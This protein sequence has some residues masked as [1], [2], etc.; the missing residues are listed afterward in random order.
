MN[1]N[2]KSS[3]SFLSGL[4]FG[5][6]A[7]VLLCCALVLGFQVQRAKDA[8][9]EIDPSSQISVLPKPS[10]EVKE[11]ISSYEMDEKIEG[12][13]TLINE[14]YYKDDVDMDQ[15]MDGIY[16]GL[17]DAV[18]DPYTRYYS[19]EEFQGLL[20]DTTGRYSGIGA[21]VRYD[22]T[23]NYPVISKPI[24][25]SP[26]EEVGLM[27]EDILIEVD[28]ESVYDMGD[29]DAVVKLIKGEEG[30]TVNVTILRGKDKERLE[31]TIQ[32]R[33]I[34]V[35]TVTY[36]LYDD[37]M[38]YMQITSFDTVTPTQFLKAKLELEKGGMKGLILDL[39]GNPGGSLAAVVT[40]AK[41][42]LPKGLIVYI[43]DRYGERVEYECSGKNE[44]DIPMVVLI[45]KGSASASE[46]L[47]GAIQDYGVGTLIGTT[48][49][50]KGIVQDIIPLDDGSAIKITTS[51][52][53]T[54]KGRNIHGTGIEPD[55][56]CEFDSEAYVNDG[57]DNQLEKAKEVLSE[58]MK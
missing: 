58:M 42:L 47:S 31:F 22:T 12:L 26:A 18:G 37:K 1:Q 11:E 27:P 43:E 19:P 36:E 16:H 17:M 54:P 34:T 35:E 51:S 4:I 24:P 53:F 45:D 38:A 9:K 7:A 6:L 20:E 21:Y 57:Y 44:I 23:L 56:I 13:I 30:T 5:L 39:R 52:Y 49:Y 50:G 29:L 28:G 46:L 8:E 33:K 48:S 15:L 41:Q 14:K 2:K 25:G 3:S 32:R 55:I 40:I 10:E